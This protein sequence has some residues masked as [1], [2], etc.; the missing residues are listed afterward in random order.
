VDEIESVELPR[1]RRDERRITDTDGRCESMDVVRNVCQ[2]GVARR[3]DVN[4]VASSAQ[5][6]CIFLRD[7]SHSTPPRGIDGDDVR[8]AQAAPGCPP[9]RDGQ[10]GGVFAFVD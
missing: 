1:Q 6:E 7:A 10:T 3:E 2:I 8:H 9:R 4:V 5:A